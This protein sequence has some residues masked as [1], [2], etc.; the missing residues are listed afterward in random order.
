MWQW[1]VLA[2]NT[3]PLQIWLGLDGHLGN[4]GSG[5]AMAPRR[6]TC[7]LTHTI[8][9]S[10]WSGF[11]A[12]TALALT[13]ASSGVS[14][15]EAKA[16]SLPPGVAACDFGALANDQTREGLNIRAEPRADSAILGRLPV[17]ENPYHEKVAAELHVIG[18]RNGWFLIE[19]AGYPDNDF[20]KRPSVYSGRGWVSGKLLS[21]QFRS[22]TIKA[23]PD[24][25]AADVAE[26]AD[27]Y[28]ITA[29]L[30]CKGDWVR[31][32]TPHY[33]LKPKL[34]PNGPR[35]AV[36]GWTQRPCTNQRTTCG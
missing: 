32:E 14:A 8:K 20:P 28:G 1:L 19:D 25:N 9:R 24:E 34:L 26:M 29:I 15:Q 3:K 21:T 4:A 7:L 22:L 17:L 33:T 31:I 11:A 16:R 6:G 27:H 10:A 12:M 18:V 5:R 30:D 2:K 36:R 13:A 23:A 35:G